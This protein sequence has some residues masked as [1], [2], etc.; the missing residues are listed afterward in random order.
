MNIHCFQNK[1]YDIESS[2]LYLKFTVDIYLNIDA[3]DN[4]IPPCNN[5]KEIHDILLT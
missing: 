1:L 3:F 5:P 2:F 4:W